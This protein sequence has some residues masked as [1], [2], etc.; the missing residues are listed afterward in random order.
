MPR[1]RECEVCRADF[2]ETWKPNRCPCCRQMII[3]LLALGRS[4]SFRLYE[5]AERERER[6]HEKNAAAHRK[7]ST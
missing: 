4:A 2:I 7:E 3:N 1:K 6:W 5:Q